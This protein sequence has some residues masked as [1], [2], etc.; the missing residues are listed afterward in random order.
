MDSDSIQAIDCIKHLKNEWK[1]CHHLKVRPREKSRIIQISLR[2]F[3]KD[4][5]ESYTTFFALVMIIES[6]HLFIKYKKINGEL[7]NW[8]NLRKLIIIYLLLGGYRYTLI[9]ISTYSPL[10]E[11]SSSTEENPQ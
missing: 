2:I 10:L 8:N 7:K 9:N 6:F 3:I 5:S 11:W 1:V 4:K